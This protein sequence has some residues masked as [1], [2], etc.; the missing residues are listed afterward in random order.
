M[1]REDMEVINEEQAELE[2]RVTDLERQ[3]AQKNL[4]DNQEIQ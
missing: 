2:K 4:T 3:L 1:V